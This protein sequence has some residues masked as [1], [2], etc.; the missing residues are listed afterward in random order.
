MQHKIS[1]VFWAN[2]LQERILKKMTNF[3]FPASEVADVGFYRRPRRL[4]LPWKSNQRNVCAVEL[5]RVKR[6][7]TISCSPPG[8]TYSSDSQVKSVSQLGVLKFIR[9]TYERSSL[10]NKTKTFGKQVGLPYVDLSQLGRR[11]WGRPGQKIHGTFRA[12]ST[13]CLSSLAPLSTWTAWLTRLSGCYC[14][15]PNPSHVTSFSLT[16]TIL[17]LPM[18]LLPTL[19]FLFVILWRFLYVGGAL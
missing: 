3:N 11:V 12:V 17:W 10:K 4:S 15:S 9:I 14:P 6:A 18:P 8:G 1:M 2:Q 7:P 16:R 13:Y 19:L 5:L